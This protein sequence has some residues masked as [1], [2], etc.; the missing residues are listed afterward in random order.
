MRLHSITGLLP[1]VTVESI[2][3]YDVLLALVPLPLVAGIGLGSLHL[4][5]TALGVTVGGAVSALTVG[6]GLFVGAP[7]S[8]RT[9]ESA[10]SSGEAVTRHSVASQREKPSRTTTAPSVPRRRRRRS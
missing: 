9:A 6:Y 1:D 3:E 2:T 5:P 8:D 7:K 4:V 10:T